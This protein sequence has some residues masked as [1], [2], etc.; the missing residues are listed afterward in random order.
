[1]QEHQ[2]LIKD[3]LLGTVAAPQC[4][5]RF[6]RQKRKNKIRITMMQEHYQCCPMLCQVQLSEYSAWCRFLFSALQKPKNQQHAINSE[7][8]Q[9]DAININIDSPTNQSPACLLFS[10]F[11]FF[12]LLL[13]VFQLLI[14]LCHGGA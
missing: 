2:H 6:F 9:H 12:Q 10:E 3:N 8:V 4:Q 11:C 7:N 1:M 13:F 5:S 14:F